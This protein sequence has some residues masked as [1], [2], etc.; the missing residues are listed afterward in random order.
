M[1]PKTREGSA[2]RYKSRKILTQMDTESGIQRMRS[3]FQ[4]AIILMMDRIRFLRMRFK[5]TR[6]TT[7]VA[8]LTP[9]SVNS[10]IISCIPQFEMVPQPWT[11]T[12]YQPVHLTHNLSLSMVKRTKS[13]LCAV[14]I[15]F[16]LDLLQDARSAPSGN[17]STPRHLTRKI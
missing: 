5:C 13:V 1:V 16:R 11:Y 10:I 12:L 9:T 6:S 3:W 15:Y 4:L 8:L 7:L 14:M 2:S 17:D